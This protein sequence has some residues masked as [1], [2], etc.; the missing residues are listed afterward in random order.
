MNNNDL[1]QIIDFMKTI[2]YIINPERE[3]HCSFKIELNNCKGSSYYFKKQCVFR[4]LT[5]V[6]G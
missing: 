1:Q 3:K 2:G 6:E 4:E 5:E